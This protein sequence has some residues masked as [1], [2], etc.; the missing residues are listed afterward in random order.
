MT[1]HPAQSNRETGAAAD[2]LRIV[3]AAR[4][5]VRTV[6]LLRLVAIA[7]PAG[8]ATGAALALAGW[9]P[10]WTAAALGA[11]GAAGAVAWAVAH[12]PAPATVARLLDARLGLRDRVAAALQ[13]HDTGG[14]IASLVARDAAARLASIRL[15]ALFPLTFGREPAVALALA[16]ALV[17]WLASSGAYRAAPAREASSGERASEGREAGARAPG[18]SRAAGTG[19]ARDTA[20]RRVVSPSAE[21]RSNDARSGD[22]PRTAGA[23][24]APGARQAGQPPR[25]AALG[26]PASPAAI[27]QP[28]AAATAPTGATARTARGGAAGATA[29]AGLS[30]GAGGAVPGASLVADDAAGSTPQGLARSY[31]TARANAEAALARD[32]IPPDHRDHVRAYFRAL[33]SQPTGAG[34]SR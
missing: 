27:G 16:A 33:P 10:G 5:R 11:A 23:A 24:M 20:A 21:P 18:A 29:P 1:A 19:G 26:Q 12:T 14:P 28:A 7:A 17:A 31:A 22:A 2:V 34:G 32:V 9:A 8:V 25:A 30:A 15:T 4:R 3:A 13:L 6:S